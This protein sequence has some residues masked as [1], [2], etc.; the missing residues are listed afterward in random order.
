MEHSLQHVSCAGINTKNPG[1]AGN[2]AIGATFI[3]NVLEAPG[4]TAPTFGQP[5][6]LLAR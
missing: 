1:P 3:Y 6:S 5:L 2:A 4:L